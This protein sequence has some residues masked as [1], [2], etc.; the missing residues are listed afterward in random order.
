MCI[1]QG[2]GGRGGGGGWSGWAKILYILCH[3]GVQLFLACSLTRPAILVAGKGS[4]RMFSF[5]CFSTFIPVPHS[6]L[7]LSFISTI[8]SISFLPFSG[9]QYKLTHKGWRVIKPQ[10]NQK[11][12]GQGQITTKILTVAKAFYY[13]YHMLKVPAISLNYPLSKWFS[14]F[15]QYKC[16]RA[17]IWPCRKKVK[18]QFKTISWTKLVDLESL[19]L[20]TKIQP[21]SFLGSKEED[22]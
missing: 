19:M 10:H 22:F 5:F 4:E 13:F 8:S 15:S 12:L 16:M 20:Y 7:T 9:R 6:S 2:Q 3:R 21:Q 1:A 14:T 11:A 17:Q 18:G